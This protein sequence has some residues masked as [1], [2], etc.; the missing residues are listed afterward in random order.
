M[1]LT[2]KTNA[3]SLIPKVNKTMK[4]F[5]DA[6]RYILNEMAI[7]SAEYQRHRIN[8]G[9]F[10]IRNKYTERS[11]YPKA[12]TGM[13]NFSGGSGLGLISPGRTNWRTMY[14]EA[15]TIQPYMAEQ[16]TGYNRMDP[17]VPTPMARI[18]RNSRKRIQKK[19]KLKALRASK[20][21]RAND[22]TK[23]TT[24]E[25]KITAMIETAKQNRRNG[26]KSAGLFFVGKNNILPPGYWRAKKVGKRKK[27]G[28]LEL[29]RYWQPGTHRRKGRKW[30]KTGRM[31]FSEAAGQAKYNKA[32]DAKLSFLDRV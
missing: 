11:I 25:G 6:V 29:I 3:L 32:L 19:G 31:T 7:A 9:R 26:D 15:G 13:S 28:T 24:R 23:Q 22:F 8:D 2:I 16:E 12:K 21:L 14:S 10:T 27:G 1:K 5:D 4:V 20:Q 30:F 17:M 18:G